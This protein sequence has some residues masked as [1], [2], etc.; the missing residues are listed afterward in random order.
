MPRHHE[1]PPRPLYE[2]W[3]IGTVVSGALILTLGILLWTNLHPGKNG[4][5]SIEADGVNY[6]ACSGVSLSADA[7]T[8][9]PDNTSYDLTFKDVAGR[10]RE[11]KRVRVLHITDLPENEPYCMP[12][13]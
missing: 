5:K 9:D 10:T 1:T 3:I 8:R 2:R 6:I 7:T 4:P 13:K 12:H 11:L